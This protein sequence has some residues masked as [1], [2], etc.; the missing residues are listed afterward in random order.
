MTLL[1]CFFTSR[2]RQI[3]WMVWETP[4][5]DHV[6][7]ANRLGI[8]KGAVEM[9]LGE[10]YRD[11][12]KYGIDDKTSLMVQLFKAGWF[13]EENRPEYKPQPSALIGSSVL[14]K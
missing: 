13:V 2:K 11:L 7:I 8:S 10:M 14:H 5:L 3:L 9:H 1:D 12:K 6:E 4:T